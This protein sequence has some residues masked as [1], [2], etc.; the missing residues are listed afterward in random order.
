MLKPA[1]MYEDEIRRLNAEIMFDLD[2]MYAE[3]RSWREDTSLQN[4]TWNR[5]EFASVNE[6]NEVVGLMDYSIDR[7]SRMCY[8]LQIINF[9]KDSL[10]T[11]FGK[12][13]NQLFCDIFLKFKF[14][15][16]KFGVIVGNPAE[17]FYDKYIEKIGGRIVGIYEKDNIL[18]DGEL[19]DFK[20]YEVLDKHFLNAYFANEGNFSGGG[21]HGN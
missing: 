13:L 16:I 6:N 3:T 20:A 21:K 12:D 15:K 8:G 1:K 19:Y 7:D 14:R 2:F 10:S 17:K 18:M 4:D 9:K 5:H 11:T